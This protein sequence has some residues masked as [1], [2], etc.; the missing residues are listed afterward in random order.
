MIKPRLG[1][2]NKVVGQ[3]VAER[4]APLPPGVDSAPLLPVEVIAIENDPKTIW[5]TVTN[6][7]RHAPEVYNAYAGEHFL[8]NLVI[9]IVASRDHEVGWDLFASIKAIRSIQPSCVALAG[10]SS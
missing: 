1:K 10:R 2:L 9:E 8:A 6:L 5:K 3:A 4:Y 7:R